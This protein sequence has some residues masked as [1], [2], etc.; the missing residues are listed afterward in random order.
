M[1]IYDFFCDQCGLQLENAH[2]TYDEMKA[3][4]CP[5]CETPL[6][7]IPGLF[8]FDVKD[9]RVKRRQ[10]LEKRFKKREKRIQ[11]ELTRTE[12]ERLERFCDRYGCRKRY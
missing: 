6:S 7:V 4:T 11:K 1:P 8:A 5:Q 12:Q 3:A 2:M 10:T 9:S